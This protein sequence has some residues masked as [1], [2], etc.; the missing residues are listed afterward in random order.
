[1]TRPKSFVFMTVGDLFGREYVKSRMLAVQ[2]H[3]E[4]DA[5][6]VPV[7]VGQNMPLMGITNVVK[8]VLRSIKL[9]RGGIAVQFG[10]R[11]RMLGMMFIL[12]QERRV[13]KVQ[14]NP[15]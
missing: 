15:Q 3:R 7:L 13:D 14:D 5:Y 10:T 1:M 8:N 6:M 9:L 2:D 4:I 11:F 12:T